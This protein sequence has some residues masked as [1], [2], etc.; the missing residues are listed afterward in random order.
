MPDNSPT[1]ITLVRHGHIVN[2][3]DI[4][5]GRLPGFPLSATGRR[6]AQAA[7][8]ALQ[9][10]EVTA[11]YASPMQRARQ[12]AHILHADIPIA[13]PVYIT[14]LLHEIDSPYD[15]ASH[16]AME[17]RS[18]N[19]YADVGPPWEQPIDLVQ[20]VRR[21]FSWMQRAHP[22]EHVVGVSHAD[23]IAF[24]IM[25]AHGRPLTPSGRTKLADLGVTDQYPATASLSTFRFDP[26]DTASV[27]AFSYQRPY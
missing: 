2:D 4:F 13:L 7:A 8:R 25:W 23:P 10:R 1:T 3:K 19:F 16:E 26:V 15:G 21:F 24:A 18:W 6:Q 5:H 11:V 22:G 12:T 27:P 14:E 20:R 17:A 9:G